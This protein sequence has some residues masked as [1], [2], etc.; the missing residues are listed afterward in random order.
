[1]RRRAEAQVG[2]LDEARGKRGTGRLI[3]RRRLLSSAAALAAGAGALGPLGCG[4]DS[5][6]TPAPTPGQSAAGTPTPGHPRQGGTLRTFGGAM[7]T[8]PD[9]HKTRNNDESLVWQWAG[10]FLVRYSQN[11]PFAVE[12]DLAETMPEIPGD[13]TTFIFK[14]RPEAKWQN[15]APVNGRAVTAEDVKLSFDRIKAL[16]ARSPR[17]GNYSGVDQITDQ[18]CT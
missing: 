4:G 9:P 15:R 1:M 3:G 8:L 2:K 16:G 18:Y 14:L 12:P 7:G 11:A 17:S 10:N 5:K 13:G 6:D